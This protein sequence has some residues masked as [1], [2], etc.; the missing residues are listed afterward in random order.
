[1][2][3]HHHAH[4]APSDTHVKKSKKWTH[5]FWEFLML[6]LAVFCGFL[7]EYK[8]EHTIEHQR[9]KEYM[10]TM[11]ED[12]R[13]DTALLSYAMRYWD[14]INNSIDSIADAVQVPSSKMDLVKVYS[15][16]NS[17]FNYFSFLPN[18][19]TISQLKNSGGFRIIRSKDVAN[20]IILYDQFDN[21][22]MV[23]IAA[24]HNF[25]YETVTKLRNQLLVQ[26]IS[27]EVFKRYEYKPPSP[28]DIYWIDSMITANKVPPNSDA[29]QQ[30]MFE[31]KNALLSYRQDYSN[32]MWGYE[33]L[34]LK[35]EEL[36]TLIQ[37]HYHLD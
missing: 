11:V 10:V 15:H 20:K 19:R 34:R 4:S 29:Q 28:S 8:L 23:N 3:V 13:S 2:E 14:T 36:I 22:A 21:D 7:A 12:L 35:M 18:D 25:F 30:T 5:Y 37:K 1:M 6:F 26:Q 17:A 9:E 31:F 32:M 16:I 24:Q 33:R 27:N